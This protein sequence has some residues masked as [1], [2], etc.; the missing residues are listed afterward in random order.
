MKKIIFISATFVGATT[1]IFTQG[2]T[3]ILKVSYNPQSMFPI[4][5][6][7][8]YKGAYKFLSY[9]STAEFLRSWSEI[10]TTINQEEAAKIIEN[11]SYSSQIPVVHVDNKRDSGKLVSTGSWKCTFCG[12]IN[13]YGLTCRCAYCNEVRPGFEA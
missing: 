3:Y 12:A 9:D 2:V 13:Y 5:I 10:I 1:S 4:C 6:E 8:R 11:K 7:T